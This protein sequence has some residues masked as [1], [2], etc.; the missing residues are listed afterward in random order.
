MHATDATDMFVLNVPMMFL[1]Y[2]L[3]LTEK[4]KINTEKNRCVLHIR[5]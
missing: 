2:V 3:V 4:T 1:L 5:A